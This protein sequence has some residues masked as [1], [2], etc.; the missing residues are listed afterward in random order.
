MLAIPSKGRTLQRTAK[1]QRSGERD[2]LRALAGGDRSAAQDL[3]QETYPQ[4]YGA[5]FRLCGDRDLAA[6]LTQETYRR[7]WSAIGG[8]KGRSRFSTWLYRIA[9]TSFL[10]HVR[11]PRPVQSLDEDGSE[12]LVDTAPSPEEVAGQSGEA[13][14]LRKAVMALP[15]PLRGTVASRFWGELPVREIAQE[16]SVT[17]VAIRKRLKKAMGLLAVA[18]EEV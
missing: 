15:E 12:R 10:N 6:D 4:I 3:I 9:Y 11:R 18:L 7:A 8:F 13:Y 16:E 5:L 14:R 17:P 2:L 1:M